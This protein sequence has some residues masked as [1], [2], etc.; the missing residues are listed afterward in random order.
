MFL[1]AY[2]KTK[3]HV[4]HE[5]ITKLI[6]YFVMT[7]KN[8][9][10]TKKTNVSHETQK[11]KTNMIKIFFLVYLISGIMNTGGIL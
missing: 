7:Q 1:Y 5:T 8:K 4:S 11:N 2:F 10:Y 6:E 3:Q 9:K